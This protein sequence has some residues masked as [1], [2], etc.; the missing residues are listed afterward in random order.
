VLAAPANQRVKPSVARSSL[1]LALASVAAAIGC[2]DDV[3]PEEEAGGDSGSG[4]SGGN[5]GSGMTGSGSRGGTSSTSATGGSSAGDPRETSRTGLIEADCVAR[6]NMSNE[7]VAE[8]DQCMVK[9]EQG[10]ADCDGQ[11]ENGCEVATSDAQACGRCIDA[12]LSD[13]CQGAAACADVQAD[14]WTVRGGFGEVNDL[15]VAADGQVFV[16][17]D[18]TGVNLPVTPIAPVSGRAMLSLGNGS[19]AWASPPGDMADFFVSGASEGQVVATPAG[20]YVAETFSNTTLGGESF[21]SSGKDIMVS[22][23]NPAGERLWTHALGLTDGGI[24]G[25]YTDE[26][27]NVYLD[28]VTES[29]FDYGGVTIDEPVAY[30]GIFLS[31]SPS[32]DFRWAEEVSPYY[33]N[34]VSRGQ[35]VTDSLLASD[36]W[37]SAQTGKTDDEGIAFQSNGAQAILYDAQGNLHVVGKTQ[38]SRLSLQGGLPGFTGVESAEGVAAPNSQVLFAAKYAANGDLLWRTGWGHSLGNS[39]LEDVRLAPDGTLYVLASGTARGELGALTAQEL[40]RAFV[41]RIAADG[42]QQGAWRLDVER[43][44]AMALSVSSAGDLHVGIHYDGEAQLPEPLTG[45]G[46]VGGTL[47]FPAP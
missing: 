17:L 35:Y 15:T 3:K 31:F 45:T 27:S 14:L 4:T 43:P 10:F 12:C 38:S 44:T 47:V 41:A 28:L 7:W 21:Q 39:T 33:L 29:E 37:H 9:C 13:L 42:K 26:D 8:Q 6:P 19:V 20:V 25:L 30:S 2:A 32:G 18:L 22:L 23:V 34:P 1:L 16:S 11:Q 46:V 24:A 36:L 5:G 40:Q